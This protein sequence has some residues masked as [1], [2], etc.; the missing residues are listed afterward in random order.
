M[1]S[2]AVATSSSSSAPDHKP[3]SRARAE[4]GG[5]TAEWPP[6]PARVAH[7]K[8]RD[9]GSSVARCL[10]AVSW[11]EAPGVAAR[12]HSRPMA[13]VAEPWLDST[14]AAAW[15]HAASRDVGCSCWPRASW[16]VRGDPLDRADRDDGRQ[17]V[18]D[19]R[20]GA[21]GADH[22]K[23]AALDA[24][25][26]DAAAP[27]GQVDGAPILANFPCGSRG[28]SLE[29]KP[30][31]LRLLGSSSFMP[32]AAVRRACRRGRRTRRA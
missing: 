16:C 20:L 27:A 1:K 9:A 10:V 29:S 12:R 21:V 17:L 18:V 5:R 23:V 31:A 30:S 13:Q 3:F 6:S 7:D 24:A 11:G 15:R 14:R 25:G 26:D 28:C 22:V 32:A 2:W 4:G 8:G 19:L